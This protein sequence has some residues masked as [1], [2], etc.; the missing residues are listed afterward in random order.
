VAG[1]IGEQAY[2]LAQTPALVMSSHD[3]PQTVWVEVGDIDPW[4]HLSVASVGTNVIL[5]RVYVLASAKGISTGESQMFKSPEQ[6]RLLAGELVAAADKADKRAANA[7]PE[8]P[9]A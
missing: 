6:A 2:L 9:A 1:G 7:A 5:K 8:K 4:F 3:A